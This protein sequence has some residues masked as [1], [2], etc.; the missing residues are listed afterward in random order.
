[1]KINKIKIT[2]NHLFWFVILF[3]YLCLIPAALW[4]FKIINDI[5]GSS[6]IIINKQDYTLSQFDYNGNLLRKFPVAL[7]KAA[8]NKI[9]KGDGRTPEG[10]FNIVNVEDASTW[11]HDF[12]DG[13]GSIQGAYGPNFV[14]LNV[15]DQKGI[16]IHGTHDDNSI[17]KRASEGCIRMHNKDIKVLVKNIHS[18]KIVVIIPGVEDQNANFKKK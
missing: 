4:Y 6:F 8:G 14:R 13:N 5:K 12:N 17:T 15:P 2:K 18:A 16:G 10:I 9:E 3:P 1:M 11:S 7:G